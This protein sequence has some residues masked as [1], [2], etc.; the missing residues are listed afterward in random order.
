MKNIA[1]QTQK[2]LGGLKMN[3]IKS[4]AEDEQVSNSVTMCWTELLDK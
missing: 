2:V 4:E 1:N 3:E